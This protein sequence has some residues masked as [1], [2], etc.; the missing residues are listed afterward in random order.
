M[1][2]NMLTSGL[3]DK[4][5]TLVACKRGNPVHSV[6]LGIQNSNVQVHQRA[7]DECVMC[8]CISWK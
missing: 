2:T 1:Y 4:I 3:I 7:R 8:Q 6:R 5:H